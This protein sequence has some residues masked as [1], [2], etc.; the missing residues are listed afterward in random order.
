MK[1]MKKVI[2]MA[3][4]VMMV[5]TTLTLIPTNVSAALPPERTHIIMDTNK[6]D[7]FYCYTWL[8][9][10]PA[11][12]WP[13]KKLEPVVVTDEFNLYEINLNELI[14]NY[15]F[16]AFSD[17]NVIAN[18]GYDKQSV[19]VVLSMYDK[20]F[21]ITDEMI[22][23]ED[24]RNG[25]TIE[26][27]TYEDIPNSPELIKGLKI[28]DTPEKTT[29]YLGEEFDPFGL[30]VML[31]YYGG[32][33]RYTNDYTVAPVDTGKTGNQQ[34]QV[35]YTA[36]TGKTFTTSFWITVLPRPTGVEV[37]SMPEHYGCIV[38]GTLSETDDFV[39]NALCEDG[40]KK[41]IFKLEK[42]EEPITLRVVDPMGWKNLS[43]VAFN[44]DGSISFL[45]PVQS[46]LTEYGYMYYVFEFPATAETAFLTNDGEMR[47]TVFYVRQ[48]AY[49]DEGVEFYKQNRDG[50]YC[51]RTWFERYDPSRYE[52][53]GYTLSP[54]E[55]HAGRQ[56]VTLTY[57]DFTTTF[58]VDVC[59]KGDVNRDFTLNVVDV[60]AIQNAVAELSELDSFQ[61]QLADLNGDGNY[62]VT[63]ATMLQ[64]MIAGI[65]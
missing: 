16:D 38:G 36:E 37:A 31:T 27:L 55:E 48:F 23:Q 54:L 29:Y 2:S 45:Q 64:M 46:E 47:T 3:L 58:E 25:Y 8:E 60:T 19:D 40:T 65:I 62:D 61:Q 41:R 39:V 28:M 52:P 14:P 49:T 51:L 4:T 26:M 35:S 57:R 20:G 21:T 1:I 59:D 44:E 13:G 11:N 5:A 30:E 42:I 56:T 9:G 22:T 12:E 18:N 24:G 43:A 17:Y 6:W 15:V 63:D 7:S 10:I 34:V 50:E 53:N 32:N 33:T